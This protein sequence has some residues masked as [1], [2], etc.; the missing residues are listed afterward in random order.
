MKSENRI[1]YTPM[2]KGH[3]RPSLFAQFRIFAE[4]P[5][6]ISKARTARAH[7]WVTIHSTLPLRYQSIAIALGEGTG[8][9]SLGG[10]CPKIRY[11]SSKNK[12]ISRAKLRSIRQGKPA[13]EPSCV[14]SVQYMSR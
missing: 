5:V 3:V 6:N 10:I 13:A 8:T 14:I 7:A 1:R 12:T 9:R 4:R 2:L 11:V